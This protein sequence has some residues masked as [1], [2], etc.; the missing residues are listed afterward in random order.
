MI[1]IWHSIYYRVIFSI[2]IHTDI[3]NHSHNCLYLGVC[4][5]LGWVLYRPNKYQFHNDIHKED[6]Y[7]LLIVKLLY[8]KVLY[9]Q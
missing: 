3:D 4:G 5:L 2:Y 9:I 6:N 7:L 8:V 1:R